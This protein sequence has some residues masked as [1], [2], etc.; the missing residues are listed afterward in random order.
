[1]GPVLA[2]EEWLSLDENDDGELVN[3]RLVEEE[4]PDAV[5]ELGVSWLIAV[6]RAWLGGNGFVFGSE[7]KLVVAAKTGR[8]ADV[9]VLL[10]GTRPPP[11]RGGLVEPPDI[12]VEFVSPSPRDERRDRVQKMAEYA[13]FGVGYY[14]LV[15]PA[16]GTFEIFEKSPAGYT[17]VVA[18]TEG[19][20][21][22]VPGCAGLVLDVDALWSELARLSAD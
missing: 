13:H 11:R 4:V 2:L 14:W 9:V 8:K 12:V 10:P 5:H 21:D 20:I 16:L 6:L 17:Q 22:P 18:V 7:L 3:G 19:T 15:D 1:M